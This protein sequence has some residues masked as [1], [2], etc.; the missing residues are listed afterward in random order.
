VPGP[1]V[2]SSRRIRTPLRESDMNGITRR[3]AMASVV[4]ALALAGDR[5]HLNDDAGG[6]SGLCA[7]HVAPP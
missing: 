6:T 3:L 7:R 5:F 2:V 4:A 1:A